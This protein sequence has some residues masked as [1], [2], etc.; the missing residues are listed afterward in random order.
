MQ[1]YDLIFVSIKIIIFF[2]NLVRFKR[3][4][5]PTKY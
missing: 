2:D 4:L 5:V 1:A 3:H